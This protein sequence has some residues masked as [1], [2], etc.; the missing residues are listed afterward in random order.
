MFYLIFSGSK[1]HFKN[2][3]AIEE[4]YNKEIQKREK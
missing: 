4:L 3:T 1:S 2:F